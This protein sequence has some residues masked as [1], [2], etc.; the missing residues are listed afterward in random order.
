MFGKYKI[1][2]LYERL[3]A[4]V[5]KQLNK[6]YRYFPDREVTINI[7]GIWYKLDLSKL[8][9]A[10]IY[11]YGYWEK[12]TSI[13]F[14]KYIKPG[15]TVLDIG[16]STGVH[17]LRMAKLAGETG[18]VYAF[19]PSDWMH[20]RLLN[21]IKLNDFK[22]IV[23]EKIALSEVTKKALYL[24]EQH[25]RVDKKPNPRKYIRMQYMKLDD[26]FAKGRIT[27]LDFIKMDVDGYE[28]RILEGATKTIKKYKPIMIIEIGKGL[29]EAYDR[30][31]EELLNLLKSFGYKFYDEKTEK[32]YKLLVD[33]LPDNASVNVLCRMK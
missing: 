27:A 3:P 12:Y 16:A 1:A 13:V 4:S 22:N 8:V 14:E 23:T 25:D 19:E 30:S 33:A 20:E 18:K 24:S 11:F 26:Y 31:L 6:L 32:E 2:K 5:K 15:M 28:C 29:Q 21:N 9:H 10:Q 7:D 17:T